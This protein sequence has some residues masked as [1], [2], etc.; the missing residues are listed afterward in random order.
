ML[1]M[2]A[3]GLV[4]LFVGGLLIFSP[5]SLV[6]MNQEM[7]RIVTRIDEGVLKYRIERGQHRHEERTVRDARC[8]PGLNTPEL[9][10]L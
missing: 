2:I 8:G 5:D 6:R 1:W 9:S 7:N 10:R 4:A 3:L